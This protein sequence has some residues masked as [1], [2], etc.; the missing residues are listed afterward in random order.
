MEETFGNRLKHAWNAFFNKDPTIYPQHGS[1]LHPDRPQFSNGGD[2]SIVTAVYNRIALDV[3]SLHISHVRLDDNKRFISEMPSSLNNCLTIE[4]NID[5]T[6]KNF[7]QD[8]VLSM[9]DEGCVALVPVETSINPQTGSFDV[10][11]MRVGKVEEWFP[12]SV[13]VDVYNEST[14][15]HEELILPKKQV[16]IVENPF[17]AIMNDNNSVAKRLIQKLSLLDIT[18]NRNSSGK[19]NLIVQLPYTIKSTLRKTQAEERRKDL[20]NQVA[21]SR[22]GVGYIDGTEKIIQLNRSIDNNLMT[23]VEYFTSMLYSQLGVTKEVL[24]GTASEQVMLNYYN[25]AVVPTATA[26]ADEMKR[27]FLT[28]T[29][30]TQKQ[31][32]EVYKDPFKLV[33]VGQLAEITDKF[34]RNEVMT[35]N[36]IRQAMGI[37][38]A[39]DPKADE[40]RNSNISENSYAGEEP[41]EEDGSEI[42]SIYNDL[43]SQL[44]GESSEQE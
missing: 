33:P 35:S 4:A 3:A 20:E 17:Y 16:A 23:Q 30:R 22:Y 25:A 39:D 2:R 5:Q 7:I 40:L 34:T 1:Y 13:R 14:G 42:D 29:A 12:D 11:E 9:F 28:K 18:D 27:K 15:N 8:A 43:M 21:N 31:S 36:E 41:V 38:P 44:G 24:D 32:I 19:M 10:D 37:K 26:L 6:S